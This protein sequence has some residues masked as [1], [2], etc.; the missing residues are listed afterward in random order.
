MIRIVPEHI[1]SDCIG[2]LICSHGSI[3]RSMIEAVQMIYGDCPNIACIGLELSC[4]SD[5]DRMCGKLVE[6][7]YF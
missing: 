4:I 1:D 2:I 5:Y 3:G 6:T 7:V